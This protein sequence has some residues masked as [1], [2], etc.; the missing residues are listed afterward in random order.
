MSVNGR[1]KHDDTANVFIDYNVSK[2]EYLKQT[3][4]FHGVK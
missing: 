3:F 1:I 4:N 2:F